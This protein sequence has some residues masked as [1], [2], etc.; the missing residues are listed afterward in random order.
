MRKVCFALVV[1]AVVIL[2][3]PA[4]ANETGASCPFAGAPAAGQGCF[5]PLASA[6][7]AL[8]AC[9]AAAALPPP[10]ADR[11][12]YA[13]TIAIAADRKTVRGTSR[14]SFTLDRSSDR[15]VFR[16]W[17]N[18]PVQRQLGARLDVRDVRVDGVRGVITEPDP[19]SLVIAR[20]T[21]PGERVTVSMGWTLRL[22]Q[23]PT[24]RL[25]S[26]PIVRLSS[27]FPLLAW[28]G[29]DWAIDPPAPQLETWTSPVSDFDVRITT[30]R[31][32]RVLAS[33]A[34]VGGGHWRALAVRDFALAAGRFTVTRRTVRVPAPVV[35]TVATDSKFLSGRVYLDVAARALKTFSGRYAPY[36]WRT[37]TVIVESTRLSLGQEYPTIVF[38]SFDLPPSVTAHETA[39]QWFYSLAG[40][41]KA[42]DPWLDEVL[43]Q[44]AT[45]RL[46]NDVAAEAATYVPSEVE[47]HLGDPMTFWGPLPFMPL[48]W[49]GLYLQGVKALASLGDDA[50][51]D[52]ALQRY[53]HSNAYRT[54]VP[55]D[56]LAALTPTLP[57]AEGVLT[58][59][60]ARFH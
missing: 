12:T 55:S 48:V 30:P 4:R 32:M 21:V 47:N 52:C 16:L 8:T 17:P 15:I 2:A 35:V 28:S 18:M 44:W 43:A 60:G 1:A 58:G 10:P 45:A 49:D 24:G 42:R 31:G 39:H 27:F 14:V 59:F 46:T 29:T 37:Y 3:P 36:P 22:P 50:G 40:D 41:D 5:R 6:A 23:K 54:A 7:A 51:V 13:M 11:P 57:N 56:L 9:P 25:E 20:S 19:T 33:G 53:V 34:G 26:A 38:L